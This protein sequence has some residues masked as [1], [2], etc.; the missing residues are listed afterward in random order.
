MRVNRSRM[1][2]QPHWSLFMLVLLALL[3]FRVSSHAQIVE[4]SDG[5][6]GPVKA[7]HLTAELTT[8]RP[9]IT[10]GGT[11]E[12]G[13][14]LTLEE[15]WHVYWVNAGDSGEPP[16]I[17]WTLPKGISVGPL[18]FPAPSRLPLGPLMD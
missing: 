10:P 4:V 13:L 8:L 7:Q 9:Q 11:L 18:Q 6:P 5:G 1:C 17:N 2:R 3:S 14:V 12:A 15:N 16:K